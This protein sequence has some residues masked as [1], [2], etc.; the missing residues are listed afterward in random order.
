M[1]AKDKERAEWTEKLQ[2]LVKP[3]DTV[4]TV[5]RHVSRSGMSRRIDLY[6]ID[7]DGP[8][9]ITGMAAAAMGMRW[10]RD[11]GGIIVGGCG[12]DMGF[13]L[14]YN[15]SRV[16]FRDGHGCIGEKCP[17]NDHSNGD[18]DRT[19]DCRRTHEHNWCDENGRQIADCP[20]G[21]HWCRGRDHWH[22]DGGYALRHRW[23]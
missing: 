20:P 9:F 8:H 4:Y 15:L 1:K 22:R 19:I 14:V 12:M 5:L 18:T 13:H 6:L 7:A 11:K 21:F 2:K 3:G 16:L 17:S 10:D 23:I